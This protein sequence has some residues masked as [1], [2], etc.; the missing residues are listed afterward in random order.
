M[1]DIPHLFKSMRNILHIH[2]IFMPNGTIP[3]SVLRELRAH[4]KKST[5]ARVFPHLTDKHID[6][7]H[8]DKMKVKFAV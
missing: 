4:D 2:D 5:G 7:G 8:F 1:Y 6:P 3:L